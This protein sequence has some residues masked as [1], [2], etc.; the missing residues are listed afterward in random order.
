MLATLLRLAAAAAVATQVA[1]TRSL[2]LAASVPEA[3]T[4]RQET[5]RFCYRQCPISC[6]VGTCGLEYGFSVRRYKFSNQC[7]SCDASSSVGINKAGDFTVCSADEASATQTYLKIDA[8][9][10]PRGPGI[11]G[12]ARK[13][14]QAASDAANIAVRK[15]QEAAE[16]SDKAALFATAK[17]RTISDQANKEGSD[18]QNAEAHRLAQQIRAQEYLKALNAALMAKKLA[19][20]KYN[21]QLFK[22][23]KQQ[24][25]TDSAEEVLQRAEKAGEEA[26]MEYTKA[27]ARAAQAAREAAM[28]GA[29][30]AGRAAEQAEAEELASAAKAA[31]RRAIMAA[32]SAKEAADKANIAATI[33]E[34]PPQPKPTLPPCN[35]NLRAAALVQGGSEEGKACEMPPQAAAPQVPAPQVAMDAG[36]NN[37]QEAP[38]AI[39]FPSDSSAPPPSAPAAQK[40][41]AAT[42]AADAVQA[43]PLPKDALQMPSITSNG[44]SD[45]VPPGV[46]PADDDALANRVTENLAE[47]MRENPAEVGNM[48]NFDIG[49]MPE[50]QSQLQ[51]RAG[52]YGQAAYQ[53]PEEDNG[54][55]AGT[56]G[57]GLNMDP[58]QVPDIG[59]GLLA[60]GAVPELITG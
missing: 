1:S 3:P 47:K 46:A 25:A 5:C 27:A 49:Q 40:V 35:P 48:A 37:G 17:F 22:L 43:I 9:T 10:G 54:M 60:A 30:A 52:V 42:P 31:Q 50:V 57:A 15:A 21:D 7:F 29:E 58:S 38:S 44:D 39:A 59:Q 12:D 56:P 45:D 36:S 26:R 6:F 19:E 33:A 11:P 53:Q 4:I 14:A 18:E 34:V 55:P 20:N 23:R 41:E 2:R 8:D 24:L 16:Q 13:A 32:K 28:S 51:A